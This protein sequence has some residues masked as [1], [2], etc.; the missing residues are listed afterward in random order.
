MLG[1]IELQQVQ[2]I[3]VDGDQVLVAH[4]VPALEGDFLQRL[5]RR[6]MQITI[7]GV[8]TGPE[9][10]E[11][12]KALRDKFRAAEPVPFVA[13]IATATRLDEVLIEEMGVRELAGKPERFEYA[14]TLREY[15]PAPAVTRETPPE[16]EVPDGTDDQIDED[17]GTLIVEVEVEGQPDFDHSNTTVT[18]EGTKRDGTVLERRVLSNRANSIWTEENFPAGDYTAS[19]VVMDPEP[20]SGSEPTQVQAGQTTR[21]KIILHPGR[22]IAKAFIVH[23]WFDKAFIEPCMRAV[24]RQVAEYARDHPDEKMIIVGHTDMVGDRPPVEPLYNQ[25]LSERRG[26]SVYAYLTYGRDQAG[27]QAEWDQLRRQRTT[28]VKKSINDTWGTRQYQYMLQDLGYYPG[29]VDENHGQMTDAAVRTFQGDKGLVVDGIVGEATWAALIDAYLSQDNLAVPESQFLPNCEGEILK[30]LGCGEQCPVRNTE[31][32]WRPNRRTDILFV[33]ANALPCEVPEPDTF[34]MPQASGDMVRPWCL[35]PGNRNSRCCLLTR[36]A[37]VQGRWLVQ[38]AEPGTIDVE[39]S[40]T[41][42]DGTP[43]ADAEYVL[44]AP[45]GEFLDG[46]RPGDRDPDRGR[47]MPG[48]TDANGRFAYSGK[49]I[50]VYILEISGPYVARLAERPPEAA[51]GNV[52]CK[53]LD[54]TSGFDVVVVALHRSISLEFVADQSPFDTVLTQVKWEEP[55]RIRADVPGETRDVITVE[56]ASFRR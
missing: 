26:R 3:E 45:D 34:Q 12:L 4:G 33:R 27:A 49:P 23:F 54:G 25:S 39:G 18:V 28:G 51:K 2:K 32:A 42:E 6:A 41:F 16:P 5:D 37:S 44:I 10:G 20:M 53:R 56:L 8:L 22:V 19:A 13:D 21:V 38:P 7:T 52:V 43:L 29:N 17:V 36:D 31:D 46:E 30:W 11:G 47:P 48:W 15:I 35:G 9:A 50:G 14:F 55:F 40:I 24:L 1:D